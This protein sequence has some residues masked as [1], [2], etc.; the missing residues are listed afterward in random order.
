MECSDK[1]H[2]LKHDAPKEERFI[3]RRSRIEKSKSS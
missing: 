2:E 3:G 1:M